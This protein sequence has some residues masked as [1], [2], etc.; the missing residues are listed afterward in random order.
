M[1]KYLIGFISGIILIGTIGIVYAISSNSITFTPTNGNWNANTVD[2]ALND[3]YEIANDEHYNN[4]LLV[5]TDLSSRYEQTVSLTNI[6]NYQNL[7]SDNFFIDKKEMVELKVNDK[8]STLTMTVDYDPETGTLTLG[9]FKSYYSD[10]WVFYT[11]YDV[12]VLL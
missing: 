12:Y 9:K 3:L 6:P 11:I 5:A 10:T 8:G 1:K 2:K 7:T 4:K